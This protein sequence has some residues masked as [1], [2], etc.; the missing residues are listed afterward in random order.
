MSESASADSNILRHN[1]CA[2]AYYF[3]RN[4]LKARRFVVKGQVD[5]MQF[6]LHV[7][8]SELRMQGCD[9]QSNR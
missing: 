5:T 4:L 1:A 6:G 8:I 7:I 2:D 9:H 3:R